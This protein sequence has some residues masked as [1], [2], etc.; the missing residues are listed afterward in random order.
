MRRFDKATQEM[1]DRL[2]KRIS[3]YV[4][5]PAVASHS[6]LVFLEITIDEDAALGRREIRVLT[7]QG[8]S[9]PLPFYVGQLPETTR[10]PVKTCPVQVL[11]KE[12][13]ALRNR[14]DDEVEVK[15]T[16]PCTMNGQIAPGEVNRYRFKAAK[17][18]RLVVTTM[19]RDLIPYIADGVPGWFQPIL[20]LYD[21][22]GNE[23]AFNDD[24]RFKP[25]PVLFFE[26]PE[27]GEYVLEITDAIY[28]GREDFVYRITIGELPFVTSVFPLGGRV[29]EPIEVKVGGWNLQNPE[30]LLPTGVSQPGVRWVAAKSNGMVSNF[31]P[32]ALDTLPETFDKEPNNGADQAQTVR[33]PVI[34]N[35]RIDQ[36]DDWDVFRIEGRAGEKI[37]AEIMARRLDS[38]MD[39]LLKLTDAEGRV[40]AMNDDH[41]D[42]G[43]GLNTH[44]ADSYIMATFPETG[45]YYLY[46]GETTRHGGE[47]YAYR[48]RISEPRPDF[49]LRVVPSRAGFRKKG[50]VSVSVYVFRKDSFDAPIQLQLK[51]PPDGFTARTVTLPP[52]QDM[53]RFPIRTTLTELKEPVRLVIEGRAMVGGREIVHEAVPAED[54]MQAFLWRHLVPSE[55]F[56]ATVYDPSNKPPPKRVLPEDIKER[57]IAFVKQRE[58]Q[59]KYPIRFTKRQ[60]ANRLRQLQRLYEEGL[61][62]DRFYAL[63]VAECEVAE[64]EL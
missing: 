3:E 46:L 44:H 43:S 23:L 36:P 40:V 29:G 6:E 42:L 35:G 33:L 13:L 57:A 54:W 27:D 55:D 17:G 64:E 30:L 2:E 28:R 8:P 41:E 45:T 11:G 51:N 47:A 58:K 25:D 59:R 49:Q 39:S 24:Y 15:I 53:V 19:A 18:Q 56:L 31:L 38:P 4:Q 10:K 63:K 62:T 20:T 21:A 34:V 61:L 52:S 60:V 22:K 12:H 7:Q 1:I 48:L 5:R 16:P 32:F 37:V 9:N 26:V 14:P 50:N